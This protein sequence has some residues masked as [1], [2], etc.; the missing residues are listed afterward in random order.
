[1]PIPK[2][3]FIQNSQGK[4]GVFYV[5]RKKTFFRKEKLTPF[6]TYSGSDRVFEFSSYQAAKREFDIEIHKHIFISFHQMKLVNGVENS[7][8]F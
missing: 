4:W 6:I 1:M 7:I 3:K 2:F 5:S 8:P